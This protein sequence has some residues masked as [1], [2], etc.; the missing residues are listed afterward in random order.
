MIY[1]Q[2]RVSRMHITYKGTLV[3]QEACMSDIDASDKQP[4]VLSTCTKA[5]RC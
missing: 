2:Q 3:R 4:C 5:R 1:T